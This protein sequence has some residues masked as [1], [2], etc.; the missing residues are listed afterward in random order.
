MSLRAYFVGL[1]LVAA[2]AA[3]A[4]G[5]FVS[6][7]ADHDAQRSAEQ[8]AR[9]AAN[10]SAER[11]GDSIAA[12][13]STVSGVAATLVGKPIPSTFT[14][15]C[16]L[17]F[18]GTDAFPR[19]HVDIISPEGNTV[20]TS[21]PHPDGTVPPGYRGAAWLARA[22]HGRLFLAPSLDQATH[23]LAVLDAAPVGHDA[24]IVAFADLRSTA[25]ELEHLYGGGH[26]SELLVT[27]GDG[28]T[29][30]SRSIAPARWTGA[31]VD[32]GRLPP[33]H[34][35]THSDV[36]GTSRIYESAPVA[37]VP[38][39]LSVGENRAAAMAA[40]TH[41][42]DREL[43]IIAAGFAAIVLAAFFIYRRVARPIEQL[44][45]A[46]RA[47]EPHRAPEPVPVSG[48]AEV[49][50]LGDDVNGLIASVGRELERR[51]QLEEQLRHAQ[52]MDALGRV[53]SGVAH[54]FNNLVTVIAG[55]TNLILRSAHPEDPLRAHA[56]QVSRAAE[57]A[58][59]LIRQLLLFGRREQ[60]KPSVVDTNEVVAD[61]RTM[62]ARV[63]GQSVEL[64]AELDPAPVAV[65]IDRGQLEQVVMNL[66]V[67]ARDAMPGGGHLTLATGHEE[68]DE[69]RAEALGLA[70]GH[71][72][73][74]TVSDTGTGMTRE[75]QERLFEPFFT[76]KEAGEGTGLGLATCY[77][78]VSRAGGR[79]DVE[80]ELG[81]G[82]TFTVRLPLVE[83]RAAGDQPRPSAAPAAAHGET[84]LVV[85]DDDGLR[86]LTRIVLEEAGY[87][88]FDVGAAE[89]AL[90]LV[91]QPEQS[92]DLLLTD[93]VMS[94]MSS[95][96][97]A[98]RFAETF[99]RGGVIYMSGYERELLPAGE[100]IDEREFLAKPFTPDA[101]LAAVRAR[102]DAR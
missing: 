30:L 59:V 35:G 46:V 98:Q 87:T 89:D 86:S 3:A 50:R 64:E 17:Q 91:E 38:W 20:C 19:G 7:Q 67:N 5:V 32:P 60:P 48:P 47:S 71:Y 10:V 54:D 40:G 57:G 22:R 85:E 33:A 31:T 15:S 72:A 96:D 42:R 4:A 53:T 99:P 37:G 6:V 100:S 65:R 92:I 101:L 12:M 93:G 1:I 84:V 69:E 44:A 83:E 34:G 23:Q 43:W 73:R 77:G 66:S 55:F 8:D 18:T 56:E 81:A 88:V 27:A 11:L 26:P 80:S 68:L 58:R 76:T 97:L 2:A 28:R 70:A 94:H 13:R 24:I 9:F 49:A 61:M 62:L 51:E 52:K 102:L 45:A 29:V 63:L 14:S 41:L 74:L 16:S 90:P 25:T 39:R 82:S 21:R 36:D 95:R 78:I 75:T 79:I